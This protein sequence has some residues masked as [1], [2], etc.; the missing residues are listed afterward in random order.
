MM[1]VVKA[2]GLVRLGVV[3]G[4]RFGCRPGSSPVQGRFRIRHTVQSGSAQRALNVGIDFV[5]CRVH[6]Y[7]FIFVGF[8]TFEELCF[9]ATGGFLLFSLTCVATV[10]K[11]FRT[12][13]HII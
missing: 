1:V 7:T 12:R 9:Y 10:S 13:M 5:V 2:T 4:H 3:G 8:I 6:M 11:Y